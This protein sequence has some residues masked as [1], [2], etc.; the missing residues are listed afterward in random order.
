MAARKTINVVDVVDTV[1]RMLLESTCNADVRRGMGAVLTIILHRT[2]NY[3]G[4]RYLNE[5]DGIPVGHEPG[6]VWEG[7]GEDRHPTYPDDSRRQYGCKCA[8][9]EAL[10]EQRKR[11]RKMEELANRPIM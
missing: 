7:E 3:D 10:R 11:Q 8:R 2:D 4:F 6:I 1:N 5:G 9:L